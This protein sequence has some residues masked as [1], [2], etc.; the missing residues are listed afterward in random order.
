MRPVF[1][2]SKQINEWWKPSKYRI[3]R[4]INGMYY[5]Q[6]RFLFF[7]WIICY[8]DGLYSPDP[9]PNMGPPMD[10]YKYFNT[11]WAAEEAFQ[12]FM[13]SKQKESP[14]KK[15]QVIKYL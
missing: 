11:Q 4:D 7:F 8:E 1:P 13:S 3:M 10:D 5:I 2:K 12:K 9:L 14:K 6:E 15:K